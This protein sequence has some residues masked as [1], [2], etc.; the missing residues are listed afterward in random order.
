MTSPVRTSLSALPVGHELSPASLSGSRERVA[1]Y[2][3]ATGD[4][5]SYEDAVPPLCVVALALAAVQD[6]VALPD[7]ALHTGQE[8]DQHGVAHAGEELRLSARIAQ[9]SQRQGYVI[10]V[11]ELAIEGSGGPVLRA[12]ATIMAPAAT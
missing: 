4:Q 3:A 2:L 6:Q 1:S 8:V 9:R 12:R 5:T 7:G 10:S 11:V